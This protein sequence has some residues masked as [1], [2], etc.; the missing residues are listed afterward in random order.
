MGTERSGEGEERT[1]TVGALVL[2]PKVY[3]RAG[4]VPGHVGELEEAARAGKDLGV[5]VVESGTLRLVDGAH[6]QVALRRVHGDAFQVAVEM[7]EYSDDQSLFLDAV[8]LNARHGRRLDAH[9]LRAVWERS[10]ELAIDV[11]A[12]ADCL[13]MRKDVLAGR[14][15]MA[16]NSPRSMHVARPAAPALPGRTRPAP[17]G[18]QGIPPSVENWRP[19]TT[20]EM[21]HLLMLVCTAIDQRQLDLRNER[22][23]DWAVRLRERL[24]R[25]LRSA[26]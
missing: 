16:P 15:P 22:L 19:R 6:R 7:R 17:P 1:V 4:I 20:A 8:A 13:S 24:E 5:L 9:D 10:R 11:E 18:P 21:T 23:R 12:L 2:D 3:F 26:A 14:F 25:A